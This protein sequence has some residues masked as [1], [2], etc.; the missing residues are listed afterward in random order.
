MHEKTG[1]DSGPNGTRKAGSDMKRLNTLN[2]L[3]KVTDEEANGWTV[4]EYESD[5]PNRYGEGTL[6]PLMNGE[7]CRRRN[8][9]FAIP[10]VD[11]RH[12]TVRAKS[13]EPDL[14]DIATRHTVWRCYGTEARREVDGEYLEKSRPH[15][16][17]E[18]LE[19][20]PITD[21]ELVELL[22][23]RG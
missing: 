17:P 20:H 10:K 4:D 18:R 8:C 14:M 2:D 16:Q 11:E 13:T 3:S 22:D 9:A 12:H 23:A 21:A 19:T 5:E 1:P 6:C 7:R 15:V